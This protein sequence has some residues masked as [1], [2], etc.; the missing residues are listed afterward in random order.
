MTYFLPWYEHVDGADVPG[1]ANTNGTALPLE[2]T[3][4]WVWP[5]TRVAVLSPPESGN[6]GVITTLHSHSQV[7]T[8]QSAI[9]SS[10]PG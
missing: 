5:P 10:E 6:R 2:Y 9:E 3:A 1:F 4:Y 7:T 8:E